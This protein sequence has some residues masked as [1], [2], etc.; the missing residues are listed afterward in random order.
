M[1]ARA[2]ITFAAVSLLWGIPYL[3][4]RIAVDG[5]MPPAFL[6]WGRV[7][8]GA[9]ILL[10]VAHRAGLL[11]SLRGRWRWVGAYAILEIAIP[12]PLIAAGEQHVSSSIAAI[13]IA[14][15]PLIV[16]LLALRF[17]AGERVNGL[18][19]VGLLVGFSGVI[20]LVGLDVAGDSDELLGAGAILLAAVGYAAGP[21][22]M[23]RKLGDLDPRAIMAASLMVAAV[24]LTPLALIAP[25]AAAPT[26]GAWASVV[27]LG[28]LCTALAFVLFGRLVIEVGAGRALV[29]TYVAPVVALAAGV[30][31]LGEDPG[32]GALVGLLLIIAGSWLS[33]GGRPP[34]LTAGLP[35]G[36]QPVTGG[37]GVATA[38]LA[39]DR[40]G[41]R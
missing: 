39:K 13:L 27:V 22:L 40:R 23:R 25:P 4:I 24:A 31:V 18:R 29:I 36:P 17:D 35:A 21:M 10:L 14:A 3:F 41:R 16:A 7:V 1:S 11:G 34:E 2:W 12:F 6:A 37:G 8:L 26:D 33:T 5:G 20:A 28:I 15:V 32:P 38:E 30:T 19:L 9:A